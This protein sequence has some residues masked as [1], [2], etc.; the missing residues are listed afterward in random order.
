[1]EKL[2]PNE[3][4]M[5]PLSLPH[6]VRESSPERDMDPRNPQNWSS[7]RKTLLFIALMSSSLLAD[8]AM[9]WGGTLITPQALEW[10]ISINKSATSMNYG[11]LL[12][13]FGGIFAV[14]LIEA[15]GRLPIWLWPQIIT[16]FIVLG[17]TLS[18]NYDTFTVFRSLQGL[19]GTV[20]Q[21]IGLPIIR[22]MYRAE[23]WPRMINIWYSPNPSPI[24]P[25]IP[26]SSHANANVS[27][28]NRGTTFL[29]G[30]FL[31]PAVA[32]YIGAATTWR[33]SFGVLTALYGVSTLLVILFG[34]ETYYNA[35]KTA[36]SSSAS[37]R[38]ASYFGIGNTTLPKMKTISYWSRMLVAYIF[39]FPLFLTGITILVIFTWPIGITTTIDTFLHSP[40]YLFNTIG[41]SSM[42]FAGVIG[43]LCGW[44][45]GHLFNNQISTHNANSRPEARLH[46]IWFPTFS[47]VTGLL[48]YGLTMHF[49]KHWIGIAFGWAMV[50]VG[51]VGTIVAITAYALEKYPYHAT[52]VSAILNMWR[53]CGG[54]AVGYFQPAW[55]ERCGLGLVFGLQAVVVVFCVV[56]TIVPVFIRER[57]ATTARAGAGGV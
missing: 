18:N 5:S 16:T 26:S 25:L 15:Y 28:N 38:L 32:G 10:G 9:V 33:I 4:E 11:I 40:P 39:R 22:D 17:A 2:T 30:P 57:R 48:T 6:D 31:G 13:G 46:G 20:P 47:M 27:V 36:N 23:E 24:D 41:A 50:N 53:T 34:R 49:Q 35:E 54:F 8:G 44:L 12:Q 14:P 52:T 51:M 55:I 43:A 1:M 45:V 37:S 56:L 29:V 3:R 42:R 7:T 21:V 19:F